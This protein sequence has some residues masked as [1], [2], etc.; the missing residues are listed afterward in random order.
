MLR[1]EQAET[2]EE[3]YEE[4]N[5]ARLGMYISEFVLSVLYDLLS[6]GPC[7]SSK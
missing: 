4:D 7:F 3:R 1:D 6:S 2:P 5:L